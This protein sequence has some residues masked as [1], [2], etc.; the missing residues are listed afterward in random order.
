MADLI[1][2]AALLERIDEKLFATDPNG[3]EQLGYLNSRMLI[4][5]SPTVDAVKHG[6]WVNVSGGRTIC[7]QCGKY[8]LYD[9]F[10][11]QK[12]SRTCPN[13]GAKMDGG[14]ET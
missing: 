13:C 12:L 4:R 1:D 10:G 2:R 7:N 5:T 6:E 3:E 8:P 14:K 9:F 11:R